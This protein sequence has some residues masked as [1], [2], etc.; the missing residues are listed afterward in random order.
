QEKL[1]DEMVG[2][3]KQDDAS[4]PY[5]ENGYW[6]YTRYE[7]QQEYPLYCRKKGTLD[8]PEEILLDVNKLAEGHA[9]FHVRHI[10]ISEDNNL[11]T[12]SADTV[13]RRRY[14]LYVKDLRSGQLIDHA[15]PNT[16]G[17]AV[18]ANDNRTFFY[19]KKD[20]LTLR[21]DRIFR[22]RLGS[23][24]AEDEVVFTEEDETF[25]TGIFKTKSK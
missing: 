2:R 22:H 9:Y 1:Y 11:M 17:Y 12:Y 19:T 18:W 8:A 21:P 4:V 15:V 23:D 3:I 5:L 13:S 10:S 6:Y 16:E 20:P 7:A 14:T 25:S 24:P